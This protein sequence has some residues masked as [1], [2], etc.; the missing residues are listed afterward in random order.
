MQ[1]ELHLFV[2]KQRHCSRL[3]T[4]Q[5]QNIENFHIYIFFHVNF[6]P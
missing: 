5:I 4:E 1:V 3:K 6:S 2:E